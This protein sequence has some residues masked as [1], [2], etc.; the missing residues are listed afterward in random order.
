MIK[1]SKTLQNIIK[2]RNTEWIVKLLFAFLTCCSLIR[3]EILTNYNF[4]TLIILFLIF[5][6]YKKLPIKKLKRSEINT[7]IILGVF[8]SLLYV[9]GRVVNAYIDN[10]YVDIIREIFSII[11]LF[12]FISLVPFFISLIIYIFAWSIPLESNTNVIVFKNKKRLFLI[13]FMVIVIGWLP[14]FLTL[15][16]GPLSPDSISQFKQVLSGFATLNDHHPI[17]HTVFI[18]IP[19]NLGYSIFGTFNAGVAFVSV[20][21]IIIMA[22]IFSKV[23]CFLNER[24]LPKKVIIGV[25]AFY[26]ISP[27]FGYYSVAIWKDVIFGGL[28]VLFTLQIISLVEKRNLLTKKDFINFAIISVLLIFFRN[29]TIYIYMIL[30]PFAIL[31]FKKLKFKMALTFILVIFFYFFVK[32]PVFDVLNIKKS[33]SA[34][35]IAMPLQMIGRMTYKDVEFTKTEKNLIDSLM[36]IEDMKYAYNPRIADGIKFSNKFNLS[37][38]DENK[39]EYFKLWL[40][41]VYKHPKIASEAYMISTL[42]YWYP[43]ISFWKVSNITFENDLGAYIEPKA[44]KVIQNYVKNVESAELPI[45]GMQWSIGL[46]FWG[47]LLSAFVCKF[48]KEKQYLLAYIPILGLWLSLIIAS[49]IFGEFRYTFGAFTTLPILALLGFMRPSVIKNKI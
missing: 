8:F 14:Y 28:F 24:H 40:K 1:K 31:T 10:G 21:Q 18:S 7:A 12:H 25:L 32:G 27:I 39:L 2:N 11:S 5:L 42:G 23:V 9:V 4:I 41:L 46:C 22:L 26:A 38:F 16:P 37:S 13:S 6:F 48:K 49:P 36:L 33:A 43:N 15:Y 3:Q 17:L 19:Y 29:N 34:E 20:T 47:I 30:F 35:Y 44:P 45:L